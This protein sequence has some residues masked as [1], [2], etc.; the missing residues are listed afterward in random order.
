MATSPYINP[1]IRDAGCMDSTLWMSSI[2]SSHRVCLRSKQSQWCLLQTWTN[3]FRRRCSQ[4]HKRQWGEKKGGGDLLLPRVVQICFWLNVLY[5]FL[6]Q[7]CMWEF[8]AFFVPSSQLNVSVLQNVSR[9]EQRKHK[10]DRWIRLEAEHRLNLFLKNY[11]QVDY[12]FVFMFSCCSQLVVLLP[13]PYILTPKKY[14]D[15]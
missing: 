5:S 13:F 4:L 8:P 7:W 15:V 6:D 10:T 9:R 12:A 14:S 2:C 1:P 3:A 11:I